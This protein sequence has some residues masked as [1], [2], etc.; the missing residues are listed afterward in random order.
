MEFNLIYTCPS[1][2]IS[3]SKSDFEKNCKMSK[4]EYHFCR[5]LLCSWKINYYRLIKTNNDIPQVISLIIYN[6]VEKMLKEEIKEMLKYRPLGYHKKINTLFDSVY[7]SIYD[8]IDMNRLTNKIKELEDIKFNEDM[9][10]DINTLQTNSD[11]E[12]AD[13]EDAI[14]NLILFD[15]KDYIIS[16]KVYD[17]I[18]ENG[19]DEFLD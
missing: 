17:F 15:Y 18:E 4:G 11:I 19:S 7:K 3:F 14:Y 10:T 8:S 6:I 2:H 1:C 16:S 5:C 12:I 9:C 13:I